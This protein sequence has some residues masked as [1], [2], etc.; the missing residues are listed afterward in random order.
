MIFHPEMEGASKKLMGPNALEEQ[1]YVRA[2]TPAGF[3][4]SRTGYVAPLALDLDAMPGRISQMLH[5]IG[6]RPAVLNASKVF[7]DKDIRS[8]VRK[9]YGEEY[10]ETLIPYLRGVANASNYMDRNQMA[11]T[12]ASEFI[13]QNMIT[14]L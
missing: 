2:T 6:L 11:M 10:R 13:R 1:N 9:F 12:R 14:T 8:V 7:Y 4:K 3:T 5:D